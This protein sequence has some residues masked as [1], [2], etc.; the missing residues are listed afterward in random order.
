AHRPHVRRR[1]IKKIQGVWELELASPLAN[2]PRGQ[3]TVSVRDRQGNE[4][5]IERTSRSPRHAIEEP[6]SRLRDSQR[7]SGLRRRIHNEACRVTED[8]AGIDLIR[9]TSGGFL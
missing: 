9:R 3:L 8:G 4:S 7:L 6:P 1:P 5:R 2:L